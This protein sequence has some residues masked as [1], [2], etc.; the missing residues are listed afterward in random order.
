MSLNRLYDGTGSW[1]LQRNNAEFTVLESALRT[2]TTE[3]ADLINYN[4]RGALIFLNVTAASGT[5]GLQVR[6][7]Y[8]DPVSGQYQYM[9]TAPTA[10]TATGLAIYGLYPAAL[11]NGNQMTNQFL[12]RTWQIQVQHGNSTNYTYSVGGCYLL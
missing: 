7:R 6:F 2:A 12:P 1:D 11:A 3:S 10:I 4:A 9:N 5:G 8:K